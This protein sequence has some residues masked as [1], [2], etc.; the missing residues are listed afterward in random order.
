MKQPQFT[1][2]TIALNDLPGLKETSASVGSQRFLDFEWIVVDGGSS[3]G[4]VEYLRG[5]DQGNCRWISEL[6]E[7]LFYAM[8]KGL[9]R[10][11]GDYI[12]FMNSGDTFADEDVLARIHT[13]IAE[14]ENHIDFLFGDAYERGSSGK[15]LL[16][17]AR[18]AE[19]I[20][21]SMF[22]HH[23]A[24]IYARKAIGDMRYDCRFRMAADYHLT[25]RLLARGARS[26]Y[27]G[28]PV[29]VFERAGFSENNAEIGRR[30]NLTIQK[31]VLGVGPIRRN[32]NHASLLAS[33]FLRTYMRGL[34][35]RLRYR[36]AAR[37]A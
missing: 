16:K 22:T 13:V 1:V 35:D 24:M 23:Q 15:L 3:D 28:F 2:V 8:N 19:S 20:K 30:E 32:Y 14:Y 11:A 12:I 34:Y 33:A 36:D 25:S 18:P 37:M 4:T 21:R 26:V 29:C 17:P 6:D 9:D 10:A 7:G 27:L 5:I 31:D